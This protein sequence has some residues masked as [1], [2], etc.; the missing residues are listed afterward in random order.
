MQHSFN[1][2]ILSGVLALGVPLAGSAQE[3]AQNSAPEPDASQVVATVNGTEIT[4]GHMI[5]LRE[6]LPPQYDQFPSDLLVRAILDQ[7][8][9]HTLLVQ[10]TDETPSL[11]TR[12]RIENETRTLTAAD[13]LTQLVQDGPSDTDLQSLY[14][15]EYPADMDAKEYRASHILV[16]SEE[17][18]I[19]LITS[20]A[21]GADFAELA[22]EFS[23][24]PSGQAGGD[25]GWFADGDMVEPFFEA[26]SALEPGKVSAPVQ[27]QFGWHVIRLA[28]TRQQE[29]PA[30]ETV[31]PELEEM[32]R[33]NLV[34]AHVA[35]LREAADITETD[36]DAIEPSIITQYDLLEP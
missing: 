1:S 20:L 26:V 21:S 35:A 23:T 31:Q 24:G 5:S 32:Y 15:A 36:V 28:E 3:N 14:D 34:E 16:E 10:S 17:E 29:R 22:Q 11:R 9:Q 4:L 30:L 8:I 19:E 18:A 7:L 27:T 6:G 25:L 13:I 2:L 12:M 33:E